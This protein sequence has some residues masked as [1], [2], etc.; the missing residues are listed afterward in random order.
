[1][2]CASRW[3]DTFFFASRYRRVKKKNFDFL[4]NH[5]LEAM[6]YL[7]G[8]HRR[9]LAVPCKLSKERCWC[10]VCFIIYR[11]HTAIDLFSSRWQMTLKCSETKKEAHKTDSWKPISL[12]GHDANSF[13]TKGQKSL[14]RQ[15]TPSPMKPFRQEQLYEPTVL[16]HF[17]FL[18]QLLRS[19][20]WHSSKS[21]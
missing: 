14:P 4:I 1:M 17:A 16:V 19:G 20:A 21:V 2:F 18:W 10:W 13:M 7:P 12:F 15:R 9:E 5:G 8:S 11:F 6:H 3:I